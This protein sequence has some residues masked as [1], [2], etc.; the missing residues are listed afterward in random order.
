MENQPLNGQ[1]GNRRTY[2]MYSTMVK[3]N[4]P[5]TPQSQTP[6]QR[7]RERT[8]SLIDNATGETVKTAKF[9]TPKHGKK[10]A[11]I[12][13]PLPERQ[14]TQRNVD[15]MSKAIWVSKFH[16][17]TTPDEI[18][19]YIVTHTEAKDKTK[20]KCTM[21]VKKDADLSQMS[22]VSYK[23][24]ATPEVY[25]ILID[26]ENWPS[27]KQV[28]EFVKLSPPK[29]KMDDFIPET[30]KTNGNCNVNGSGSSSS[31]EPLQTKN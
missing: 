5:V 29:R 24:D 19:N 31:S 20:F 22:F 28:R 26:P 7:Q 10:D 30:P 4:L 2:P 18:A 1:F 16:P 25:D 9:P 6:S 27:N 14:R 23:I 11:Q 13:R 3:S 12:G 21:L 17:E 8:I 15:P